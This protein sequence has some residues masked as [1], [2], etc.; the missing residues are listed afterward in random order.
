MVVFRCCVLETTAETYHSRRSTH[1][2]HLCWHVELLMAQCGPHACP[3]AT[4]GDVTG[5][6]HDFAAAHTLAVADEDQQ[7]A[8]CCCPWNRAVSIP[9]CCLCVCHLPIHGTAARSL[10]RCHPAPM[11]VSCLLWICCYGMLCCC[12]A[13]DRSHCLLCWHQM[14]ASKL[15]KHLGQPASRAITALSI[16]H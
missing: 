11:L 14:R 7:L 8:A 9:C 10:I 5:Q 13:H 4:G 2:K 3:E 16:Q 6:G 15:A 12:F 1:T